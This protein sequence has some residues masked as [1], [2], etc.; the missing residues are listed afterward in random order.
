ARLASGR[1]ECRTSKA[2]IAARALSSA[3]WR[4]AVRSRGAVVLATRANRV[5]EIRRMGGFQYLQALVEIA[6]LDRPDV[7]VDHLRPLGPLAGGDRT[8][9]HCRRDRRHRL[10]DIGYI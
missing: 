8:F 7:G 4:S 3:R 10:G 2:E 5:S 6:R 9:G 1:P